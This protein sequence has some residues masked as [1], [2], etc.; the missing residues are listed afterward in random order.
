MRALERKNVL[1]CQVRDRESLFGEGVCD[2][3]QIDGTKL[4]LEDEK[5]ALARLV[6]CQETT[7]PSDQRSFKLFEDLGPAWLA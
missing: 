7:S 2:N 1:I 6:M 5:R 3:R 4:I